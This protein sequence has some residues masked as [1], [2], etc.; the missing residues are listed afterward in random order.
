MI[1]RCRSQ[2][3]AS[4]VRLFL[5]GALI[6]KSHSRVA[7]AVQP[8]AEQRFLGDRLQRMCATVPSGMRTN[9]TTY[10]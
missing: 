6:G 10:L 1:F 2:I 7:H 5:F 9:A 3:G 4:Q 8:T